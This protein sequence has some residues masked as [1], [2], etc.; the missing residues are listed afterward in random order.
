M[1]SASVGSASTEAEFDMAAQLT[2]ASGQISRQRLVSE[3]GADK[4]SCKLRASPLTVGRFL[5]V[6]A[7]T[8]WLRRIAAVA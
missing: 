3:S 7:M 6:S 4:S 5:L 8:S 1:F 2:M